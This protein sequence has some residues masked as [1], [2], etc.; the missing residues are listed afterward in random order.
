VL[1]NTSV[2]N[3]DCTSLRITLAWGWLSKKNRI[4]SENL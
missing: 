2:C 1:L 4:C 3:T